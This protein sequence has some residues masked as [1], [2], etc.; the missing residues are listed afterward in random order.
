MVAYTSHNF[1][2]MC[3]SMVHVYHMTLVACVEVGGGGGGYKVVVVII[4]CDNGEVAFRPSLF[5]RQ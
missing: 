1:S 4:S 3:W 5:W 2:Y